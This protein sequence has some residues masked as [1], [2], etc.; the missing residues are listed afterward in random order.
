ME[1]KKTRKE[2]LRE[3][4]IPLLAGATVFVLTFTVFRPSLINV[5]R[6]RLENG[7]QRERLA[8]L[9]R[10]SQ[11]LKSLDEDAI[12]QRVMNLEEVFP[13]EKPVF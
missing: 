7:R 8:L 13:S 9:E 4:L 2:K 1:K 10:K 12:S 5:A 6:L 3:N 11:L